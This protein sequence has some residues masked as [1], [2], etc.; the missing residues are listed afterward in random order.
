MEPGNLGN[1]PSLHRYLSWFTSRT[2][3]SLLDLDK[4]DEAEGTSG[5]PGSL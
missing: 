2:S 5:G 3:N 4:G 1:S